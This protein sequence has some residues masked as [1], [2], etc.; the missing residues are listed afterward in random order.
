MPTPFKKFHECS[1]KVD[2]SS[3]SPLWM[4]LPE[5]NTTLLFFTWGLAHSGDYFY[6]SGLHYAF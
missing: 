4:Q 3:P 1:L 6:M 2:G 5:Y